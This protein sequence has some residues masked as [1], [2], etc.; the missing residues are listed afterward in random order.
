MKRFGHCMSLMIFTDVIRCDMMKPRDLKLFAASL[1]PFLLTQKF[2]LTHLAQKVL[3]QS[4]VS[5]K[6]AAK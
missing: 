2:I 3:L 4:S 6:K 1:E 5:K